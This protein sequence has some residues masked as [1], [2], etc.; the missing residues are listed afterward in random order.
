VELEYDV[1]PDGESDLVTKK[2]FFAHFYH[3]PSTLSDFHVIPMHVILVLDVG[4]SMAGPKLSHA[5]DLIHI[6][7]NLLD[8]NF[9]LNIIVFNENITLWRPPNLAADDHAHPCTNE[10]LEAAFEFLDTIVVDSKNVSDL[11]GAVVQAIELD[12][13]VGLSGV[14]PENA[15]TTI[16]LITDGRSGRCNQN[17]QKK[18]VQTIHRANRFQQIPIFTLGVGFDTNMD[19]L[20]E[21]SHR[22][23]GGVAENCKEDFHA[24]S[25]VSALRLHL[26]DVILKNVHF[27]YAGKEFHKNTLTKNRFKFFHL[28]SAV[29]VAGKY[30]PAFP[31]RVT[32]SG[33]SVKGYYQETFDERI[34]GSKKVC[35]GAVTL[36]SEVR[37]RGEC[38]ILSG[39]RPSLKDKGFSNRAASIKIVGDCAWIVC[40]LK[41]YRGFNL[42]LLPGSYESLP[43]MHRRISSLK[44]ISIKEVESISEELTS[45][46]VARYF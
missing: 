37:F 30:D 27:N 35:Q 5:K 46:T 36:C 41:N 19:L 38:I 4:R 23:P 10:I 20:E 13:K 1:E 3:G 7:I 44:K 32:I 2:G 8:E 9:L 26:K 6:I 40:E 18:I 29:V 24:T 31:P 12:H 17:I 28:G 11:T 39:S 42:T 33:E 22:T 45:N 43:D 15:L 34:F 14:L 25:Q 16:V 21:I